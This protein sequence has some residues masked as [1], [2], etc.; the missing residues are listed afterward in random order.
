LYWRLCKC[1]TAIVVPQ[2]FEIIRYRSGICT[3]LHSCTIS[4]KSVTCNCSGTVSINVLYGDCIHVV[5]HACTT[6]GCGRSMATVS[7]SS[8][9]SSC[10]FISGSNT[11]QSVYTCPNLPILIA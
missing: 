8:V 1:P 3:T 2:C 6:A 9:S 5:T 10:G 11:S 4:S 7:L